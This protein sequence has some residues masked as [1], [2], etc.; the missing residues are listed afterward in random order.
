ML[1]LLA[2]EF[3]LA[4]RPV[5]HLVEN[6]LGL[7]ISLGMIAKLEGQTATVLEAVDAELAA[8][9]RE[10]PSTHID[11]TPWREGN[12]KATLWIG[13]SDQAT[14]FQISPHRTADVA[15]AML[16]DDPAKVVICDRYSG[17]LWVVLKQWCWAHLR[18]DFQAMIDRADGGSEV[19]RRLLKLSDNLF[20]GWHRVASGELDWDDFLA[21]ATPIQVGV[22]DEL[23]LGVS[24]GSPKTAATC[25]QLLGGFEHLWRFLGGDGVEPTNNAAER[26]LRH[27]VMWRKSSGGTASRQGS[28]FV[29]RLMGVVATCRQQSRDVLEFLTSCFEASTRCEPVPSLRPPAVL[30]NF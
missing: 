14:H 8:M 24:C 23:G 9:V 13:Q 17:Y 16:G 15:R 4:K 10:A 22:R 2:A 28:L 27:G 18:R 7:N 25:R 3:R 30:I 19:G 1:S 29:S 21:W 26:G 5:Q 20:W 6:F 12:A 11:E